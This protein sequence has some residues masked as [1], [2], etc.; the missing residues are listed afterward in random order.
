MA[1][2]YYPRPSSTN[3]GD[4]NLTGFTA[5]QAP[6]VR[7]YGD[8]SPKDGQSLLNANAPGKLNE[9]RFTSLKPSHKT[10]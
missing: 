2:Q 3:M 4:G 9:N 5:A 1:D 8:K 7:A 10:K 6:Q